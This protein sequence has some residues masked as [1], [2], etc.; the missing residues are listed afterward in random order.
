MQSRCAWGRLTKPVQGTSFN[1]RTARSQCADGGSIPL[2]SNP[3]SSLV[4]RGFPR[5]NKGFVD[6]RLVLPRRC[7]AIGFRTQNRLIACHTGYAF[8]NCSRCRFGHGVYW[9]VIRAGCPQVLAAGSRM[10]AGC[11]AAPSRRCWRFPAGYIMASF[12]WLEFPRPRRAPAEFGRP[13]SGLP[14][15]GYCLPGDRVPPPPA[16]HPPWRESTTLSPR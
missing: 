7:Q 16:W 10:I 4:N 5:Q 8:V 12:F 3:P 2:V 14:I 15:Y 9:P 13:T 11:E 6:R 1:G